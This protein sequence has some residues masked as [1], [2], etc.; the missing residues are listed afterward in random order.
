MRNQGNHCFWGFSTRIIGKGTIGKLLW[1][2]SALWNLPKWAELPRRKLLSYLLIPRHRKAQ[3]PVISNVSLT[4]MQCQP[5]EPHSNSICHILQESK[6]CHI[7]STEY[8]SCFI[9]GIQT[10]T[11]FYPKQISRLLINSS[12]RRIYAKTP[13]AV[14]FL[15]QQT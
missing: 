3:A 14:F 11:G 6:H 4:H 12:H 13:Q 2:E 15:D 5:H 1:G 9:L 10:T 7:I 8:K